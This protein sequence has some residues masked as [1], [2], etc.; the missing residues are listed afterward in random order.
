M[1]RGPAFR[2]VLMRLLKEREIVPSERIV[3]SIPGLRASQLFEGGP[4]KEALR[5]AQAAT[6]TVLPVPCS[7]ARTVGGHRRGQGEVQTLGTLNFARGSRFDDTGASEEDVA[8]L[9]PDQ[10]TSLASWFAASISAA[11][12]DQGVDGVSALWTAD[13]HQGEAIICQARGARQLLTVH[14][15][16]RLLPRLYEPIAQALRSAKLRGAEV[17]L[18][19]ERAE[20]DTEPLRD[21]ACAG[22]R[23]LPEAFVVRHRIK[24]RKGRIRAKESETSEAPAELGH[25][26]LALALVLERVSRARPRARRASC[27]GMRASKRRGVKS[28]KKPRTSDECRDGR[29]ARRL[30]TPGGAREA[31][32]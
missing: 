1:K 20:I 12:M 4:Y 19:I 13:D 11:F 2:E 9:P 16:E 7:F 8:V 21:L 26:P 17:E 25:S 22:W 27:A 3:E 31:P 14:D 6:I 30:Q 24:R 5:M 18:I 32:D 28:R 23:V 10:L 29:R 15:A